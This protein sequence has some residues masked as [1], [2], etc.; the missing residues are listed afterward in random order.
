MREA[1][2]IQNAC[3]AT[4][5]VM[6]HAGK[7]AQ[8]PDHRIQ[9][10]GDADDERIGGVGGDAFANRFHDLQVDAQE[11]IA[12]H[13][14]FAGDTGSHD[15]DIRA[16]DI[17]VRL[18]AFQRGVEPFGWA[19]FGDVQCFAFRSALGDVK[20]DNV[21]KFLHCCEVGERAADLTCADQR[22]LGSGHLEYLRSVLKSPLC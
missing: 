12:A 13:A 3:H 9:R 7:L 1:A 11:V 8:G 6:W 10:V 17:F 15:A 19:G 22:D 18:G 21:T 5:L 14:R 4:D 20:Q 16:S 2:R